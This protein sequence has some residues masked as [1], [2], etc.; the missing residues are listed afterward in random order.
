MS[1]YAKVQELRTKLKPFRK[2]SG[3]YIKSPEVKLLLQENV[4]A[5]QQFML[6]KVFYTIFLFILYFNFQRTCT[7]I[8]FL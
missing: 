2:Y 8:M 4:A 5:C 1:G 3:H 6:N 7:P